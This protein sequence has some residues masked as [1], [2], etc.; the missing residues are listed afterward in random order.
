MY[1]CMYACMY[2]YGCM[3]MCGLHMFVF[4]DFQSY[5]GPRV[6][7][8]AGFGRMCVCLNKRFAFLSLCGG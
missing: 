6:G 5:A 8:S 1:I 7:G 2:E 4:T 3:Y